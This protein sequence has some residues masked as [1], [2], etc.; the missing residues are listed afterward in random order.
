MKAAPRL[1]GKALSPGINVYELKK[2]LHTVES[3]GLPLLGIYFTQNPVN[4]DQKYRDMR[5]LLYYFMFIRP[6]SS[7]ACQS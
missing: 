3:H 1:G 6:C 7:E 2:I 5:D 4:I